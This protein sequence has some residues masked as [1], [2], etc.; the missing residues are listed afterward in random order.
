MKLVVYTLTAEGTI[1][2]YI[3]DGGYFDVPNDGSW[4]QNIDLVGVATDDAPQD[5]FSNMESLFMYAQEKNL[6]FTDSVTEEVIPLSDVV[7]NIWSKLS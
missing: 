2:D 6:V 3:K 7:N 1:P 4:P 5:G